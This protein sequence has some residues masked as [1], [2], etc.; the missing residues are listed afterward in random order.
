MKHTIEHI[1]EILL[2]LIPMLAFIIILLGLTLGGQMST[3]LGNIS[4]WMFGG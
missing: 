1:L 4:N 2:E 3:W